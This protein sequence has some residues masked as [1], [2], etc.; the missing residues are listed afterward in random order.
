MRAAH[1]IHTD[2]ITKEA[3]GE[4]QRIGL[5]LV[6]SEDIMMGAEVTSALAR[7]MVEM[8]KLIYSI[9]EEWS[10]KEPVAE[11]AGS[12]RCQGLV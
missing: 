1:H 10:L 2:L 7:E 3:N 12:F 11:A 5:I 9:F 8:Y 6:H 4:L